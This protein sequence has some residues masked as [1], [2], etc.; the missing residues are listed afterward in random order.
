MIIDQVTNKNCFITF[1]GGWKNC[2]FFLNY[3]SPNHIMF[4]KMLDGMFVSM[5]C[6]DLVIYLMFGFT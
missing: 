1:F 5:L 3:L 4:A 2:P 6:L